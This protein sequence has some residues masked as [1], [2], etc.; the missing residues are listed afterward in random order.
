MSASDRCPACGDTVSL[1]ENG[2][3]RC[4]FATLAD[5]RPCRGSWRSVVDAITPE[6][7]AKDAELMARVRRRVEKLLA[8]ADESAN[9]SAPE[10]ASAR[11]R[12][13]ELMAQHG[14]KAP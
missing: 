14:L 1:L 12:A 5:I 8:L 7:S 3:M 4:H 13:A 9:P 2:T 10:A 6:Q 11:K